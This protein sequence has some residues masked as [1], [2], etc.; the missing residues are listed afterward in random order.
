PLVAQHDPIALAKQVA[1]LDHLSGGRVVLGIG[2][3]WNHEEMEDHA[4]DVARRRDV[5]REHMLVMNRLWADEEAAFAGEFVQLQPSWA[6]PKPP[7]QPRVR[8]LLGG[9]G[10]PVLFAHIAE[11]GD[12]WMP[13][14]GAGL[15]GRLP[16]LRRAV[17][18]ACRDP[19]A[20]HVVPFGTVPDEGKLDHYH[21]IGVTEV[22]LR[23]PSAPADVGLP[24][25]DGYMRFLPAR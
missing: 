23:L 21:S 7:Q 11:Y 3:G 6:W 16:E 5:V 12:G 20:L 2:F 4:I 13:I 8:T 19:G 17:E 1:T 15:A 9:A 10:G 18:A 22:V 25:L 24:V 14:G